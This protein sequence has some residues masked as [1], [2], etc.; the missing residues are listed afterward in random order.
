M[1]KLAVPSEVASFEKLGRV[2]SGLDTA[3][4]YIHLSDPS[5]PPT[6]AKLFF[7]TAADLQILEIDESK[8][9][10]PVTWVKGKM[11]DAPPDEA[12]IK[13]NGG[14][15]IH[16]LLPEGCVHVYG[17]QGVP[18]EAV[19]R[20]AACPLGEDGVHKFPEWL[21]SGP[22]LDPAPDGSVEMKV[23]TKKPAGAYARGALSFLKGVDAKPALEAVEAKDGQRALAAKEAQEAKPPVDHLRISGLGEAVHVAVLAATEAEADGCCTI[24]RIQTA[25][26][27]MEGS[28]RDCAQIVIDLKRK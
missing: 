18:M 3:D 24:T 23:S 9:S 26:P 15:T 1:F 12:T 13:A 14:V 22:K 27:S 17:E 5:S 10:G 19:L 7:T 21:A 2:Q 4:G 6:V 25:Y 8:L 20:Q 11:G 16:Y 28:G